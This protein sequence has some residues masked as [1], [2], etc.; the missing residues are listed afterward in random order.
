MGVEIHFGPRKERL[1]LAIYHGPNILKFGACVPSV[2]MLS[3]PWDVHGPGA[4]SYRL[5]QI[6]AASYQELQIANTPHRLLQRNNVG[7]KDR[8][9]T[10]RNDARHQNVQ[11]QQ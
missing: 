6:R 7:E 10:E 4:T 5:W 11:W 1:A 8:G 2:A 9:A 3:I